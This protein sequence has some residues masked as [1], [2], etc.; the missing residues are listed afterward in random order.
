[1]AS[2]DGVSGMDLCTSCGRPRAGANRFCTVCGAEFRDPVQP[3]QPGQPPETEPSYA[4]EIYEP[5]YRGEPAFGGPGY[6]G[7]DRYPEPARRPPGHR[8]LLIVI[9]AAAIVL[10]AAGGAYAVAKSHGQGKAAAEPTETMSIAASQAAPTSA[11]ASAAPA[12][13]APAPPAASSGTTVAVASGA[14]DNPAAAQVTALVNSYFTAINQHDYSA[15]SGLL[16]QQA[17]QLNPKSTFDSG[18]RTT[19]DSAET[20]TSISDTGSGGLAASLTFTSRQS[21]ADSIDHSSCDQWSITLF[22]VPDGSGYLIGTP[23]SN[24]GY[25]AGHQPC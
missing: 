15:Y 16:D 23:P 6:T 8:N 10:G 4:G 11:P 20:L 12:T 22:L 19:T 3:G 18:Y 1:M 25:Q 2:W 14:A 5:V 21:P 9:A 17:R 24:S 7:G 13:T